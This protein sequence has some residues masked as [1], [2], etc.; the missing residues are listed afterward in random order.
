MKLV[1]TYINNQPSINAQTTVTATDSRPLQI[2]AQITNCQQ[3]FSNQSS[4]ARDHQQW[5]GFKFKRETFL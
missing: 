5:L 2:K 4:K 3:V 1:K